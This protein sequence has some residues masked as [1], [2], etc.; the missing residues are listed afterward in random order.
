[1]FFDVL[2]RK[3]SPMENQKEVKN[4]EFEEAIQELETI[5]KDLETG[6]APL[7]ESITF[8]ERGMALKQH[9]ESKLKEAQEKIEKITL[10]KNGSVKT[11]PLD[12]E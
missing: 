10:D 7:S 12:Q 3:L 11:E 8:Y 6:S 4:L 1:M 5:I 9:C 2:I